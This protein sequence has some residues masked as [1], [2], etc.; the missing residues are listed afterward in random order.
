MAVK[1]STAP[2]A[3]AA[4]K[5]VAKKAAPKKAAKKAGAKKASTKKSAPKAGSKK[6][7]PKKA[8]GVRLSDLQKKLLSDVGATR[9]VGY[10]ANKSNAKNLA[11]L[12]AKKLIKKV[13]KQEGGF[14][15]YQITKMGEKHM[16]ASAPASESSAAPTV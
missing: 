16:P 5:A 14:S 7:A 10:L 6:A 12:Q 13:G 2:K 9:L 1:K 3:G 8:A 4:K 15:R 11:S